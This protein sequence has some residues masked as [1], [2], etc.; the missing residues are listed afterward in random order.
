MESCVDGVESSRVE[1]CWWSNVELCWSSRVDL[2]RVVLV[3]LSW[4]SKVELC[5]WKLI[6]ALST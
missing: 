5:W 1:L 3:E 6:I 4:W 2:S